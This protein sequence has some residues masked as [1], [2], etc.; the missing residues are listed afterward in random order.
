MGAMQWASALLQGNLGCRIAV[1]Q[2]AAPKHLHAQCSG[3]WETAAVGL[4]SASSGEV[5]AS[6]QGVSAIHHGKD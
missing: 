1:P 5:L 2:V 3:C 6:L 4:Q